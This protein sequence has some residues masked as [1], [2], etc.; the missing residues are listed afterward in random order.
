LTFDII[1]RC[2]NRQSTLY[3]ILR[4]V[5]PCGCDSL[6]I[7]VHCQ[8]LATAELERRDGEHAGTAAIVEEGSALE[9]GA[10]EP[11][12]AH[13]RRGV[14]ARAE[15]EPRVQS[16]DNRIIVRLRIGG[17]DPDAFAKAH[18]SEILEPHALPVTILKRL[19]AMP[20]QLLELE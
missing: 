5:L 4:C 11:L 3:A 16:D 14:R 15:S 19:D 7:N 13:C 1:G 20:G 10:I 9:T 17:T 8:R 12:E 2:C 6:H 18:G